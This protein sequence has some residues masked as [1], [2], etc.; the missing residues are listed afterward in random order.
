MRGKKELILNT[1]AKLFFKNGITKTS[2]D[3][4]AN[5][6][7][8]GKGTIYHYYDSKEEL[9]VEVTEKE[10]AFLRGA[11]VEA[12]GRASGPEDRLRAYIIARCEM[13]SKI[14]GLFRLFK[15]EYMQYYSYIRKV[16]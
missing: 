9:F 6:A 15:E 7:K 14:A 2:M 13:V 12:V 4:I 8:I 11:L 1:A 10:V 3:D 16:Q 5:E